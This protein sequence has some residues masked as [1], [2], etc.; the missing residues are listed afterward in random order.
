MIGKLAGIGLL[1]LAAFPAAATD[2]VN[3]YFCDGCSVEQEREMVKGLTGEMGTFDFYVGNF[4]ARAVHKYQL[5]RGWSKPPCIVEDSLRDSHGN[6]VPVKK[7]QLEAGPWD[8]DYSGS[9][10]AKDAADMRNQLEF[11]GAGVQQIFAAPQWRCGTVN[12][13]GTVSVTCLPR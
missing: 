5:A 6:Y 4:R 2:R 12:M 3:L 13:Q 11:L 7:A 8:F 1:M 9:G 10:R